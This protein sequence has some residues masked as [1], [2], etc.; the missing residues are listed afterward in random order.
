MDGDTR[1]DEIGEGLILISQ[2]KIFLN[3]NGLVRL[4]EDSKSFSAIQQHAIYISED[5]MQQLRQ[6]ARNIGSILLFTLSTMEL[7]KD[8]VSFEPLKIHH[9][10]TT[11]PCQDSFS[12]SRRY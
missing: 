7:S 11:G 12:P 10:P 6:L 8:N 9:Y 2:I 1:K 5:N 3:E 4:V